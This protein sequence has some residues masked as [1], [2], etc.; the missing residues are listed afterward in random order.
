MSLIKD[1]KKVCDSEDKSTNKENKN[2]WTWF[3]HHFIISIILILVLLFIIFMIVKTFFYTPI[4]I[5]G[6]GMSPILKDGDIKILDRRAE[7][8]RFDVIIF[9]YDDELMIRRVYGMPGETVKVEDGNIYIN[10][11]KIEDKYGQGDTKGYALITL[12]DD[13]YFVLSDNRSGDFIDSREIES[14]K[15]IQ[16]STGS[17]KEKSI[18]GVLLG[19]K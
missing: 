10:D 1:N 18:M 15:G 4:R 8:D 6:S 7:I 12:K 16:V 17:V 3:K 11:V 13:E 19:A 2:I 9:E 5:K 14:K